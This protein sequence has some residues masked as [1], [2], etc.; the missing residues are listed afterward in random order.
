MDD[1]E[2]F[3]QYVIQQLVNFPEVVKI[4][5]TD[6]ERGTL[7][8]LTVDPSDMG[9]VL[10]KRGGTAQAVRKLLQAVGSKHEA[11]YSLRIIDVNPRPKEVD[12][13][14]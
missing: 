6:D 14:A 8:S 11:H 3:L 13:H 12:F 9:R 10:G 5:R 4:E 7:L 1:V 2:F